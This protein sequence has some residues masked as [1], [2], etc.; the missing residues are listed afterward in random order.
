MITKAHITPVDGGFELHFAAR[1]PYRETP[2]SSW[3][4]FKKTKEDARQI[5]QEA[6]SFH[7]IRMI[8]DLVEELQKT[9]SPIL[10]PLVDELNQILAKCTANYTPNHKQL[11]REISGLWQYMSVVTADRANLI[12]RE[13][14]D[15]VTYEMSNNQKN[16]ILQ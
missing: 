5:A 2:E 11:C 10:K 7:I 12:V 9:D 8:E 4:D 16:W 14:R 6:H 1:F 13:M 3:V 15:T